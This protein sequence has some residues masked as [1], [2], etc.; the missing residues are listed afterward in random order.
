M[1]YSDK[2]II[3]GLLIRDNEIILFIYKKFFP[4]IRKYVM[5]NSGSADDAMDVF[6][7]SIIVFYNKVRN[8][9]MDLSKNMRMAFFNICKAIWSNEIKHRKE[10]PLNENIPENLPETPP[11]IE[12]KIHVLLTRHFKK[13]DPD[14]RRILN[15]YIEGKSY[16]EMEKITGLSL[17]N[18]R[19]KKHE[20]IR[21]LLISLKNDR[22]FNE[23]FDGA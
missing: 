6:Q 21:K 22:E 19:K 14:H 9:E 13:I 8:E 18:L 17:S 12:E 10:K 11:E 3:E 7:E 20:A 1:D 2:E 16:Q 5:S 4:G 15:L 23:L